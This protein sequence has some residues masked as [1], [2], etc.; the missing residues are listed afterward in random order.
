MHCMHLTLGDVMK[1]GS[2]YECEEGV[3]IDKHIEKK[4]DIFVFLF[5]QQCRCNSTFLSFLMI[6]YATNM[7]R[8]KKILLF[9]VSREGSLSI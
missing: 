3:Y 4:E 8:K 7:K 2:T 6:K 9:L 5:K 1:N